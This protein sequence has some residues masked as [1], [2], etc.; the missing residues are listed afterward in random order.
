[1][2]GG[3]PR[4]KIVCDSVS[5]VGAGSNGWPSFGW[6]LWRATAARS[7]HAAVTTGKLILYAEAD[8]ALH[9]EPI[10]NLI[11]PE[12]LALSSAEASRIIAPRFEFPD[13]A[14][15]LRT[16]RNFGAPTSRSRQLLIERSRLLLSTPEFE[17]W[18]KD[19]RKKRNWPSQRKAK[20]RQR[21]RGRPR[22]SAKIGG[23]VAAIVA[24]GHWSASSRTQPSTVQDLWRLLRAGGH[25]ISADGVRAALEDLFVQTGDPRY[26]PSGYKTGNSNRRVEDLPL[27][28]R[29]PAPR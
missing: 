23:A 18:L 3:L 28:K 29:L 17:R 5:R 16:E 13:E 12:L 4:P 10:R 8:P 15:R 21:G 9:P 27:R 26:L 11:G 7:L 1:M 19:E 25:R 24:R 22:A 6:E 20:D 14:P 2:F